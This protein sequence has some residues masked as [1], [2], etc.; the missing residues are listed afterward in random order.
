MDQNDYFAPVKFSQEPQGEPGI[1]RFMRLLA[2]LAVI[3]GLTVVGLLVWTVWSALSAARRDFAMTYE[4]A[5]TIPAAGVRTG[6]P[7][8]WRQLATFDWEV[9]TDQP[10]PNIVLG[11]F[12]AQP[13]DDI[14]MINL[15]G[16]TDI[17]SPDGSRTSVKDPK[18]QAVSTF[19]SWDYDDNGVAELVP[20]AALYH[21]QPRAKSYVT[22]RERARG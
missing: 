12:N 10:R 19:T 4:R 6:Q 2:M 22:I 13:G 7:L 16:M 1:K 21:Y 17:L 5:T 8:A 15:G 11:E 3:A 14:L 9:S 18:W 20:T